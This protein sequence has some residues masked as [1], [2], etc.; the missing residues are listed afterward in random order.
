[1]MTEIFNKIIVGTA[2]EAEKESFFKML[3]T[4]P[5]KREEFYRYKNIYALSSINPENYRKQQQQSFTRFWDKVHPQNKLRTIKQILHYAAIIT[6]ATILGFMTNKQFNYSGNGIG[7]S[8]HIEYSSKKGSISTIRLEDGS[9]IWLNSNTS[10]ILEKTS[11]NETIAKLYGEA[12]FDLTPNPNR[13]FLVNLEKFQIKDI[14]TQFNVRAYD[15]EKS[16]KTALIKGQIELIRRN[17]KP[18]LS[19]TPGEYVD[20][21]KSSDNATISKQ[22]PAIIAAWKEGKF[23]FI[24]QTLTDICKELEN[25]YNIEIQIEDSKLANTRYT[26]VIKRTTTVKMVLNIL[27]V[28]DQICYEITDKKEGKDFIRIF[29]K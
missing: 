19:I 3:A 7:Q 9:T 18:I 15:S 11:K 13:A 28:T 8:Q 2:T 24:D 27:S 22:D 6:V 26:S 25:W 29:K 20:Y 21:D 1:M 12:F 16:I 5:E 17:G 10:L 4:D 23:V 14:G